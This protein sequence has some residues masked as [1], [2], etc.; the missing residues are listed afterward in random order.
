MSDTITQEVALT[1]LVK[2]KSLNDSAESWAQT[3]LALL[4]QQTERVSRM[5]EIRKAGFDAKEQAKEMEVFY[6]TGK[7]ESLWNR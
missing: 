3:A 5:P 2:S 7:G 4:G 6:R 1:E